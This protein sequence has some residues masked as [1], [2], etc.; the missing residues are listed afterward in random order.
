M[1][2]FGSALAGLLIAQ[3]PGPGPETHTE[4]S[5]LSPAGTS[6]VGYPSTASPLAQDAKAL[7]TSSSV[8]AYA[9]TLTFSYGITPAEQNV[10]GVTW[11]SVNYTQSQTLPAGFQVLSAFTWINRTSGVVSSQFCATGALLCQFSY[12]CSGT[13]TVTTTFAQTATKIQS[14]CLQFTLNWTEQDWG[15]NFTSKPVFTMTFVL[16][17]GHTENSPWTPTGTRGNETKKGTVQFPA[18]PGASYKLIPN[19][20]RGCHNTVFPFYCSYETGTGIPV[21]GGGGVSSTFWWIPYP[22]GQWSAAGTSVTSLATNTVIPAAN[23]T[24]TQFEAVLAWEN[25]PVPSGTVT[26]AFSIAVSSPVANGTGKVSGGPG[27][28]PP[29]EIVLTLGNIST[30]A[31]YSASVTW[32]NNATGAF[33][34]TYYL[35]GSWL[36][37]ATSVTL[38][39]NGVAI[40]LYE[41]AVTATS[42]TVYAGYV[43]VGVQQTVTFVAHYTPA[44]SFSF[45]QVLVVFGGVSLTLS[46]FVILSGVIGGVAVLWWKTRDPAG[47]NIANMLVGIGMFFLFWFCLVAL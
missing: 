4:T 35:Q 7:A 1:L 43:S 25:F 17:L 2:L 33:N 39:A 11:V 27:Q 26:E 14:A 31:Q 28:P 22:A 9:Q 36:S 40:P 29:S 46:S 38:F 47:S 23:I 20:Q 32:E 10:P 44:P 15:S 21:P 5:G 6:P 3:L 24:A 42:I 41:Y 12:S 8:D 45:N 16:T 18:V 30:G 34:G 13:A 19:N 37:T